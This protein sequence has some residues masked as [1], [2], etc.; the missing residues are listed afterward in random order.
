MR[1]QL[2][3]HIYGTGKSRSKPLHKMHHQHKGKTPSKKMITRYHGYRKMMELYDAVIR[4]TAKPITVHMKKSRFAIKQAM[5][6]MA[7]AVKP[8]KLKLNLGIK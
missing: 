1:N 5:N 6:L 4:K 3:A 7:S 2:V 8:K